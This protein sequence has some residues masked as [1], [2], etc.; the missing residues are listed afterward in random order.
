MKR[1]FTLL[2][3]LVIVGLVL[4]F[5]V[6]GPCGPKIPADLA[7]QM[8]GPRIIHTPLLPAVVLDRLPE[9]ITTTAGGNTISRG[10]FDS[11]K[12]RLTRRISE[13]VVQ[14][15]FDEKV[16]GVQYSLLSLL[17]SG[18]MVD[19]LMYNAGDSTVVR[20]IYRLGRY[21][22]TE[23]GLNINQDT[24]VIDITESRNFFDKPQFGIGYSMRDQVFIS[25]R[26]RVWRIEFQVNVNRHRMDLLGTWWW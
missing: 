20:S 14:Q 2:P 22:K 3:W 13:L 25:T 24:G 4:W 8:R 19:L 21:G 17:Q 11:M 26:T 7:L 6:I 9:V 10:M 5:Q 23:W 16:W 15:T 1:A 12:R 18:R